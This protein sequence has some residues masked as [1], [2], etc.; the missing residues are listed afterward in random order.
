MNKK[1]YNRM[2]CGEELRS[3]D[4]EVDKLSTSVSRAVCD[5][6]QIR[7]S[8]NELISEV[9]ALADRLKV[10]AS[11]PDSLPDID[12]SFNEEIDRSILELTSKSQ[13]FPALSSTEIIVAAVAG[14]LSVIMDVFLVGTPEVVKIYHGG[15]NFD[16]SVLTGLL[17]KV[18]PDDGTEAGKILKWL[19]DKCKV[20]YDLSAIKD[21]V[22]PNNHRL[23]GLGHDP[24][25]GL[26]FAV[27]DIIMGTTTCIDD[28]GCLRIIPNYEATGVEKILSVIYYLGHIVSD[29]FTERGIPIPG[30][31][32]TQFFTGNGEDASLAEIAKNMYMDGY[33][34]RHLA[35]MS[36]P[37]VVK[38][39]IV[40]AY[41]RITKPEVSGFLPLAE[42][43]RVEQQYN[44]KKEKMLFI[45]NSVGAA[46]NLVKFLAPPSCGN[47][48]A[49]N[50][51]QW[52]AFIRSSISMTIA[53]TRERS[54][55]F[56]LDG[57]S[58]INKQ[59][60]TLMER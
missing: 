1:D 8:I 6:E 35:S 52:F 11:V 32:L 54:V 5:E 48:C 49:L 21:T 40:N 29:L 14:T 51:A 4:N 41:C 26:F 28:N 17:R 3:L 31:F 44:L 9:E 53:A 22:N 60:E 55:E 43:E 23:R 45:S 37:V 16:G 59:W 57:R 50:V 56:V 46:G 15:E 19:S 33:D 10:N 34:T 38:D 18:H 27:A 2:L 42:K 39:I 47:P 30:F 20:P 7:S 36:V 13:T 58:R 24:Y 25:L 12:I